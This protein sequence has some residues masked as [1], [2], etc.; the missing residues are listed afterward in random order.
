MNGAGIGI[1]FVRKWG[2]L[3][4]SLETL[5]VAEALGKLGAARFG[6]FFWQRAESAYVV[7]VAEYFLR[8]SNRTTVSRY[9][10][11]FLEKFPTLAGLATAEPNEVVGAAHWAGLRTRTAA[12]P[13]SARAFAGR[14][15]WDAES[16]RSLPHIGTYAAGAIALYGFDE[17]VFPM[18]NNVTRVIGRYLQLTAHEQVTQAANDVR[19]AALALG[20]VEHLKRV[21]FGALVLG[22]SHCRARPK[23]VDCDLRSGCKSSEQLVD[24][25]GGVEPSVPGKTSS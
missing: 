15:C 10:P 22:W 4:V 2:N 19:L 3:S 8:R 24:S 20:G 5:E 17:P 9:L 13:E 18:D 21:H 25:V 16:L 23:C 11:A 12:L 14:V 7:F 6:Q 1:A